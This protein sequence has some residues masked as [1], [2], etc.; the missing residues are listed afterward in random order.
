[1]NKGQLIAEVTR[2]TQLSQ[3][4][5]RE[6]LDAATGSIAA[7]LEKKN[8]VMLIGFGTFATVK[9]GARMVNHPQTGERI[10]IGAKHVPVFRPGARLKQRIAARRWPGRPRK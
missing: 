8:P 2:Q 9:R 3:E 10:K 6:V 1:M 7:A 5:V 4:R